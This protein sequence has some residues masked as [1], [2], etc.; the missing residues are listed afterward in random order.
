MKVKHIFIALLIA[1]G[2]ITMAFM[3]NSRRSTKK[4]TIVL[5]DGSTACVAVKHR[6]SNAD[7]ASDEVLRDAVKRAVDRKVSNGRPV[8]KYDLVCKRPYWEYPDGRKE[9]VEEKA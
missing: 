6:L 3:G 7:R 2:G 5:A 1:I 8:A 9:Y 4:R